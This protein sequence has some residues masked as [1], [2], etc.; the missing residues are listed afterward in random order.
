MA[1]LWTIWPDRELDDLMKVYMLVQ[2]SFWIQQLLVIHIEERRKDHWQM[3]MHH[4]VTITL[5]ST[6]YAYHQ[7][8]VGHLILVMM[9][10]IDLTFPVSHAPTIQLLIY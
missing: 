7:T 6:C 1:E 8:K 5:I 3:L 4:F 10:T 2:W 9:D